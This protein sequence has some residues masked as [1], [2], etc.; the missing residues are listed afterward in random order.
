MLTLVQTRKKK[1]MPIVLFGAKYWN[2]V[3]NFDAPAKYGTI[4]PGDAEL[5]HRTDSVDE[6]YDIITRGLTENALENPGAEL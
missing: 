2:E 4:S 3:L 5:F 1:R 6:A